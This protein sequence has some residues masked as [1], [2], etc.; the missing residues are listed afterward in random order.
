MLF[1]LY[2]T[3]LHN[4]TA[5]HYKVTAC[6]IRPLPLKQCDPDSPDDQVHDAEVE[7]L[8]L[9]VVVGDLLLLFL[10]LPHQLFSL[11]EDIHIIATQV[12]WA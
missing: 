10:D 8:L 12:F 11:R 7:D 2:Q 5:V 1:V 9:G 3:R 4:S 6:V